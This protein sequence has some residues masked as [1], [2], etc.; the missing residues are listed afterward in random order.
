M[1]IKIA[2]P[3]SIGL[4][5]NRYMLMEYREPRRLYE[6]TPRGETPL[7]GPAAWLVE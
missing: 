5:T 2:G 3:V 4:E 7:V 6:N 1:I